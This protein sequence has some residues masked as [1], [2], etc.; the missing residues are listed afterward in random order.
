MLC[1]II[2]IYKPSIHLL[3]QFSLIFQPYNTMIITQ[4]IVSHTGYKAEK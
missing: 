3:L 4:F 2:I 1:Y